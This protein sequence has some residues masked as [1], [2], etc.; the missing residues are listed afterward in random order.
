MPQ[1]ERA[2]KPGDGYAFEA[3]DRR[4]SVPM[5]NARWRERDSLGCRTRQPAVVGVISCE[6]MPFDNSVC[7]VAA[8]V[9]RAV[10]DGRSV[11]EG[12]GLQISDREDSRQGS[13]IGSSRSATA[14]PGTTVPIRVADTRV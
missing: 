9:V 6:A 10:V 2:T 12:K 3:D 8:S 13:E 5:D 11:T 1:S 4:K 14:E 7:G